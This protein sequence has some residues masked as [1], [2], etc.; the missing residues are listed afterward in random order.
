METFTRIFVTRRKLKLYPSAFGRDKRK[1]VEESEGEWKE[2][3]GMLEGGREC[4]M[5]KY[6]RD[7]SGKK[8]DCNTGWRKRVQDEL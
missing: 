3:T 7:L 6:V 8:A 2:L 5:N 1:R 4:G